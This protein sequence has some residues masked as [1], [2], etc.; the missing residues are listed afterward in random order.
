MQSN[1]TGNFA[2]KNNASEA[3]VDVSK[4]YSTGGFKIVYKG[5]FTGG[6]RA[7]QES[8]HKIFKTGS[9]FESSYFASE[10]KVVAKALQIINNF[11]I[12]GIINKPIW[13]NE[14]TIWTFTEARG[15]FKNWQNTKCIVEPFIDNFGKFNS[16][17][18]W[19]P[20]NTSHWIEA[21][22]ALS[23]YSYHASEGKV[24][25]CD[26]QGGCYK[27]GFILTDPVIISTTNEYGP[28]DLGSE[29]ISTFFSHHKCNKYCDSYWIKPGDKNIY[30]EIK[31]NTSMTLPTRNSRPSLPY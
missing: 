31:R 5:R 8:I 25:L 16:N 26:L 13:L 9:V 1:K 7:G 12:D 28:T 22:Q 20:N 23:H 19:T 11:N 3:E 18:G 6:V 24:L 15:D 4:I 14:P 17:S 27:N 29:G 21:M 2:R 10:L 30:F